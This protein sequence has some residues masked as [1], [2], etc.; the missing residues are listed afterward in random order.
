MLLCN[1][2]LYNHLLEKLNS[3]GSNSRLASAAICLAF[4]MMIESGNGTLPPCVASWCV[5]HLRRCSSSSTY[6]PINSRVHRLITNKLLAHATTTTVTKQLTLAS[7]ASY[8][9]LVGTSPRPFRPYN[10]VV[11]LRSIRFKNLLL[12]LVQQNAYACSAWR[13]C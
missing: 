7:I 8:L 10:L 5:T 11:L 6:V 9:R 4:S 1:F 12:L 3:P 13:L 2:H